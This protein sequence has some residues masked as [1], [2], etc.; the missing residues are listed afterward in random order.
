MA[1]SVREV[2]LVLD[3]VTGADAEDA[4]TADADGAHQR[5]VCRRPR[6]RP[7]CKG[8]RIGVLR[9]RFV[10]V[11]G[12]REVAD[13][14][15]T[16]VKEMRAGRRNGGRRQRFPT[17]TPKYRAARGSAPGALKAG[18]DRVSVARR[19]AGRKVLT[20]RGAAG[21]GQARAR[22]R[23]PVSRTRWRR[24]QPATSCATRAAK[25]LSPAASVPRVL[26][27]R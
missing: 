6:R 22:Q 9:Q 10:G 8:A 11:T 13:A 15:G 2:A 20:H 19:E 26:R 1:K 17:S 23:A 4:A 21:V 14:D 3:Q 18:V 25:L 12:E 16:V 7:R 5:I 27:R 24:R